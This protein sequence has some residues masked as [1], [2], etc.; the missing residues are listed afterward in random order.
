MLI[1][2]R[3]QGGFF[4]ALADGETAVVEISAGAGLGKTDQRHVVDR[5]FA[6]IGD[7][8]D[9][10]V[11]LG[12]GRSQRLGHRFGGRP[13]RPAF[14]RD[15]LGFVEGGRIKTGLLGEAGGRHFEPIGEAID[16]SPDLIVCQHGRA[17]HT[18]VPESAPIG[19]LETVI[20]L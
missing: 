17:W 16:R 1:G 13:T 9:E 19:P 5:R 7:Q 6:A 12:V 11:D 8:A 10:G 3:G 15:A 18:F 2:D 20:H 4:P 14:R